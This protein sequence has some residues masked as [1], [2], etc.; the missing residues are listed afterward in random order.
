MTS[1]PKI[2]VIEQGPSD[3]ICCPFCGFVCCPGGD[4]EAWAFDASTC[5]CDHTLFVATDGD[6]SHHLIAN[7]ISAAVYARFHHANSLL[8]R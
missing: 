1:D 3:P 5:V 7:G 6:R 8:A 2:Q 4:D